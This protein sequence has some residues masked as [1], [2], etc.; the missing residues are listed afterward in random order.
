MT[1]EWLGLTGKKKK[2]T[3]TLEFEYLNVDVSE[4]LG[5]ADVSQKKGPH[6]G[7]KKEWHLAWCTAAE[8][9][10]TAPSPVLWKAVFRNHWNTVLQWGS[11]RFRK[12]ENSVRA[13]QK[14][15]GKNWL[16]WLKAGKRSPRLLPGWWIAVW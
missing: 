16:E 4:N 14:S 3:E 9:N 13:L 15:R 5:S 10:A 2:N 1:V 12:G 6:T 11:L 7:G 8:P